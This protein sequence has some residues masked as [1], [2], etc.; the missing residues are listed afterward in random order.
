MHFDEL[1]WQ[2][3]LRRAK[4][5][6]GISADEA[7]ALVELDDESK[8]EQVMAVTDA[9]R[10][11][12]KQ[13]EVYTC[14]ITNA[15]SGACPEKCNFCSQSA[16]FKAAKSPVYKLKD[17]E[18]IAQEAQ[19]AQDAGVR[20]FSIVTQGRA[21]S[22][23]RE[24][25][26]VKK[27]LNLIRERTGLQTCA[28]VGLISKEH[29]AE[30]QEAGMDAMHHNLETARSFHGNIVETHSYDDEVQAVKN[31]KELGMYVCSGGIFGMGENWGH[32]VELAADLR[33]LDVD[34]VPLNFLNARPGTPL[35]GLDELSP[36]ECLKTIAL[37]RLMLPTKDL[38]VCGGRQVHLQDRQSE[39]FRAGANGIMLGDYLTTKGGE[40]AG[41][42]DLLRAQGMVVRPPPHTPNAPSLPPAK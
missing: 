35:E 15:K 26:E 5:G 38:I 11:H 42:L 31:A 16:H 17:A 39:L 34:S 32:R 23:R 28:S 18:T 12:F 25:D 33:E 29:L 7:Q 8:L 20:E 37:Y 27:A 14:G 21:L 6:I 40:H 24:I 4:A 30:L 2:D 13:N 22:Q 10:L 41:D 9:I 1:D 36:F 19:A 3:I